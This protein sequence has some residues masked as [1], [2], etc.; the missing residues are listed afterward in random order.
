[1]PREDPFWSFVDQTGE[2][3]LWFGT[4][5]KGQPIYKHWRQTRP[6]RH[7]AWRMTGQPP[8]TEGQRLYRTCEVNGCIRPE[9]MKPRAPAFVSGWCS[10][11][12]HQITDWGYDKTL[13]G[14]LCR[15]CQRERNNRYRQ[16]KNYRERKASVGTDT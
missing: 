16:G 9:H 13:G 8:L 15:T 2:H 4:Y 6:A 7:V 10:I 11:G 12:D 3:W 1:M 14:W 5:N